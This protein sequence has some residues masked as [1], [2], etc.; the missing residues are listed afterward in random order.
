MCMVWCKIGTKECNEHDK[1]NGDI[2]HGIC[3]ACAKK[4]YTSMDTKEE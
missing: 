2:S 4:V 3:V 1:S